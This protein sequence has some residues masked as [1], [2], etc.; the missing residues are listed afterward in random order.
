M[1]VEMHRQ[2]TIPRVGVQVMK[3]HAVASVGNRNVVVINPVWIDAHARQSV[4]V[5]RKELLEHIIIVE[6]SDF[7]QMQVLC[8]P[9]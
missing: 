3:E 8:L 2:R 7:C 6:K 9:Q 4:I 1:M 5:G